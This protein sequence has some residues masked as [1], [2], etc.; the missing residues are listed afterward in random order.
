MT[1]RCEKYRLYE[2]VP[3][4]KKLSKIKFSKKNSVVR[5]S[6]PPPGGALGVSHFPICEVVLKIDRLSSHKVTQ[7]YINYEY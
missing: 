3:Q 6:L 4:T 7:Y 5:I 1:E 2:K